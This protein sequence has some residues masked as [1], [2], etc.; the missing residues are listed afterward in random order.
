MT[1]LGG[2]AYNGQPVAT[3]DKRKFNLSMKSKYVL[4]S[5]AFL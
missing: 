2:V 3:I 1:A 5:E 4:A